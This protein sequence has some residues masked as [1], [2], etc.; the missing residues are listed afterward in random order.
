MIE[1]AQKPQREQGTEADVERRAAELARAL[2]AAGFVVTIRGEVEAAAV[3]K[4]ACV[5][6]GMA[7]VDLR[8][9]RK[10][11]DLGQGPPSSRT[12]G[13]VAFYRLVDVL[14]WVGGTQ[15]P[16]IGSAL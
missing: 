14:T 4:I 7:R 10:W 2:D 6:L 11:R 9:L 13:T 12:V 3:A 15:R 8:T 1:R 16:D 5:D